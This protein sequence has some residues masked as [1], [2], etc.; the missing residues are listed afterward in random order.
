[1][2]SYQV[3]RASDPG[4]V[5][6]TNYAVSISSMCSYLVSHNRSGSPVH[7]KCDIC[8]PSLHTYLPSQTHQ[9]PHLSHLIPLFSNTLLASLL[10]IL[11]PPKQKNSISATV[12]MCQKPQTLHLHRQNPPHYNDAH[13]RSLPLVTPRFNRKR[14]LISDRRSDCSQ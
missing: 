9:F 2:T 13:Q 5:S 8:S 6:A 7:T 11:F 3:F 10:D 4:P 1:M 12:R 14:F